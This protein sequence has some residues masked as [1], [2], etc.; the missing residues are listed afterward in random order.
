[1]DEGRIAA[2]GPTARI[3]DDDELLH[4]HGLERP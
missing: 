3:L 1:M 4:R 2:D